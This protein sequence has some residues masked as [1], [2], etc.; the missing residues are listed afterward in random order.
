[1]AEQTDTRFNI[2]RLYLKSSDFKI[3]NP[4]TVFKSKGKLEYKIEMKIDPK[5]LDE[6]NLHDVSLDLKI[7]GK[8]EETDIFTVSVSQAG[9]FELKGFT[10]EQMKQLEMA[11]CPNVLYPYARQAV[12]GLMTQAGFAPIN[13]VPINFDA[14]YQQQKKQAAEKETVTQN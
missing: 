5:K 13:L 11:Y 6:E 8:I 9:V 10:P 2:H 14:L 1:M 3:E 7:V 4:P 12:T